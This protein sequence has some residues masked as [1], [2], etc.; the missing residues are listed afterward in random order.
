M[1]GKF[2]EAFFVKKSM[3]AKE[4]FKKNIDQVVIYLGIVDVVTSLMGKLLNYDF[5]HLFIFRVS[6]AVITFF[7][8]LWFL[9]PWFKRKLKHHTCFVKTLVGMPLI[10]I[11]LCIAY[12][13]FIVLEK[14]QETGCIMRPTDKDIL[15]M[16]DS[17]PFYA[18]PVRIEAAAKDSCSMAFRDQVIVK[19]QTAGYQNIIMGEIGSATNYF[20]NTIY[21]IRKI[22]KQNIQQVIITINPQ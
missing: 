12:G 16:R 5:V 2:V 13:V 21:T 20:D 9:L 19:L 15:Q 1:I 7:A 18:T 22:H 6:S 8:M 14:K 3:E 17:I 4:K 11:Q 10:C